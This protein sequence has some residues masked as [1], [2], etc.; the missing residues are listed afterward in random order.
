VEKLTI[1]GGAS[2]FFIFNFASNGGISLSGSSK[3]VL[4]GVDADQILYNFAG[5]GSDISISADLSGTV[6]APERDFTFHHAILTG[7]AFA[8]DIWISS[9]ASVIQDT[10]NGPG[11]PLP[12]PPTIPEPSSFIML[13]LG[14]AAAL[15]AG[16]KNNKFRPRI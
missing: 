5:A 11:E 10:Y 8:N 7:A 16:N 3:L 12:P 1:T 6:L 4:N 14:S 13:G 9:G 15:L 2:D